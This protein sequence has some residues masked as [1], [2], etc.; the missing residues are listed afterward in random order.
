LDAAGV[1]TLVYSLG[2][3]TLVMQKVKDS[4]QAPG[5]AEQQVNAAVVNDIIAALAGLKV[6]RY[7]ADK[8]ADLKLYGLQPAQRTIVARTRTGVTAT[9]YLGKAEDGSKRVYGRIL[10]PN[11]TDV[12]VLSEADSNRLVKELTAFTK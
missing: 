10:D 4:W 2:D 1:E 5:R 7:V 9:L 8:G 3:Q 11:R 6:E 12:F